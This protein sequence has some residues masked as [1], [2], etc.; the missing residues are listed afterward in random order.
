MLELEAEL[1]Q[2]LKS[3]L[4]TVGTTIDQGDFILAAQQ[5]RACMFLEK[6]M[7]DIAAIEESA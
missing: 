7:A 6:F 3:Q 2:E 1:R 5:I 4:T